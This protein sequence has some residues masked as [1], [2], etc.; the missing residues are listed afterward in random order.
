M[1]L[2][3][4]LGSLGLGMFKD[5]K[6]LTEEET[7]SKSDKTQSKEKKQMTEKDYLLLREYDCPVCEWKIK[8][9]SVK[10]GKIRKIN[11]DID[12]RVRYE[13][14]DPVK[15]D[16]ISCPYCGYSAIST[17]F[18]TL[19]KVQ[20]EQIKEQ[21]SMNYMP[22]DN[23][24]EESE[25]YSYKKAITRFK[26]AILCSMV[27]KAKAS[28]LAF[29]SLKLHWLLES[30]MEELDKNS[31]EYKKVNDDNIECMNN[32]YDGFKK[33]LSSENLPVYGLDGDTMPY[34]IAALGYKLG[35]YEEAKVTVG[36]VITSRSAN[37]RIKNLARDLKEMIDEKL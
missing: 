11:H 32:A 13:G 30:Y 7:G 5:A 14:I 25:P 19:L 2:F 26:L 29:L 18:G 9:L 12:M 4:D 21:V 16:V 1:G 27:K 33:A 17:H 34:I 6:V 28:E 3:S 36:R 15:Y 31:E 37:E 35:K 8:S 20:K 23:W 10:S 24:E 22:D